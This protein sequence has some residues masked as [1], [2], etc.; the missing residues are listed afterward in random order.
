MIRA[1]KPGDIRYLLTVAEHIAKA[2]Y[3]YNTFNKGQAYTLI[4]NAVSSADHLVLVREIDEVPCGTIGGF[5]LAYDVFEKYYL[6][7]KLLQSDTP[8]GLVSL[9][10]AAREWAEGRRKIRRVAFIR[11]YLVTERQEQVLHW[12]MTR[13]EYGLIGGT[14]QA[15]TYGI[16]K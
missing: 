10:T 5:T 4:R 2:A 9:L 16:P 7:I 1:A 3:P 6:L 13:A 12:A 8:W 11:D 15:R 14:Y